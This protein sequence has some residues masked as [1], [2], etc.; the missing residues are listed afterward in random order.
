M[1]ITVFYESEHSRSPV[2]VEI[3]DAVL[4]NFVE[5]EVRRA[6]IAALTDELESTDNKDRKQDLKEGVAESKKALRRLE[7]WRRSRGKQN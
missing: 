3:G 6:E 5:M 1:S 4:S 7:L 2:E